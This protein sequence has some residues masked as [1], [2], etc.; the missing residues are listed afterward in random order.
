MRLSELT[1][2]CDATTGSAGMHIIAQLAAS[3]FHR[4]DLLRT[5]QVCSGSWL[6]GPKSLFRAASTHQTK[7]REI[8]EVRITSE[9]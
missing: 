1:E 6:W 3:L 2:P 5:A 8:P 9:T 7:D 4:V